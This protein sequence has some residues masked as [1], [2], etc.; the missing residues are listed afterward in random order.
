MPD[1]FEIRNVE[2]ETL[3]KKIS[4][5]LKSVMPEGYGF[6]LFIFEYQGPTFM[7]ASSAQREDVI[8][9]MKEFIE[10]LETK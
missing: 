6:A 2:V 10:K 3:L 1:D 8:K 4:R 7:Y 5:G 9:L